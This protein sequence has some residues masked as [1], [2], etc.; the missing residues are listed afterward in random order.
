M[1]NGKLSTRAILLIAM[2]AMGGQVQGRTLLQKR[3]YFLGELLDEDL[4]FRSHFYGP[5]SSLIHGEA[6]QATTLGLLHESS[7]SGS[8]TPGEKGRVDYTLTENGADTARRLSMLCQ[9]EAEKI[10]TEVNR[11]MVSCGALDGASLSIA[12]KVHYILT[13]RTNEPLN[14]DQIREEAQKLNWEVA[15]EKIT[16]CAESLLAL[17]LVHLVEA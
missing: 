13:R 6:V 10:Q 8:T 17:E 1:E 5:Y 15:P 14:A 2:K 7:T 9:K 11:L 12:A 4:G 16:T 3:M